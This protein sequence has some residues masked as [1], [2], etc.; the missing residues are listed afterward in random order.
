MLYIEYSN[1]SL[2]F[3]KASWPMIGK[4]MRDWPWICDM[5]VVGDTLIPNKFSLQLFCFFLVNYSFGELNTCECHCVYLIF[6][7]HWTC[8]VKSYTMNWRPKESM[9]DAYTQGGYKPTWEQRKPPLPSLKV[10]V[11]VYKWCQIWMQKTHAYSP[12]TPETLYHGDI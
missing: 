2:H 6:R 4:R 12:I 11:A 10:C 9:W 3:C 7:L 1:C 8:Y 5:L